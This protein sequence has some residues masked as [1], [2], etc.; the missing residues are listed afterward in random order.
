[1]PKREY[2]QQIF[3]ASA[4]IIILL[5]ACEKGGGL[6]LFL[7]LMSFIIV[8]G[9]GVLLAVAKKGRLSFVSEMAKGFVYFGWLG[10]LIGMILIL[11]GFNFSNKPIL[12]NLGP[13]L[14]L[15]MLPLFYSYLGKT[16][17]RFFEK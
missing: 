10:W 3:F 8:F 17:C 15:A 11:N 16:I 2:I 6:N 5:V 12:P 9:G 7:D 13:L 1:M 14:A 4:S